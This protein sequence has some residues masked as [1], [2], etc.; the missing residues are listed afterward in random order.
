MGKSSCRKIKPPTLQDHLDLYN[1]GKMT[2]E[3]LS[4]KAIPL[5]VHQR[6]QWMCHFAGK[7]AFDSPERYHI[8]SPHHAD[9]W[10]D[11]EAAYDAKM[12]AYL[13]ATPS[14]RLKVE[15][16]IRRAEEASPLLEESSE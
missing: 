5:L 1:D 15:E 6:K 9:L 12:K 2:V 13:A 10:N 7:L 3:E 4:E 14:V 16:T 11:A 8:G